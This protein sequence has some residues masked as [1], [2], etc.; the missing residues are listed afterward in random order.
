MRRASWKD[1]RHGTRPRADLSVWKREPP[2]VRVAVVSLLVLVLVCVA[3]RFVPAPRVITTP[4]GSVAGHLPLGVTPADLNL[5]V[6]TLDTTRADRIG[7]Y[8]WRDAGTPTLDRIAKDGVLFEQPIAPAPLTLPAHCSLFTGKNPPQHGVRDNG[9]FIL[10]ERETTLA[11]RLKAHG[12]KTAG[13]IGAWVLDRKWGIAQGFDTYFDDF[14]LSKYASPTLA[15][16]RRPGNEVADHALAWLQKVASSRF[17]AWVHFY[18]AHSPYAPPEPFRSRFAGH[19]Y[20]GELAF[21]DSQVARLVRFLEER[22]LLKKTIV[23]IVGDHGESLGEHGESTHGFFIYQSVLRVPLMIL[24]PFDVMH[25]RRVSDLVRSVDAMPT[26]LDLLGIRLSDKVDGR[27][28]VPLMTGAVH[29]LG[30]DAYSEAMYARYHYGWSDLRGLTSGRFKYIDAPR[31][32]LYDIEQDPG[33]TQNLYDERRALGDRMAR[34]LRANETQG[35]DEKPAVDVDPEA[36][37]RLAA[38]GYVGTFVAAPAKE[39]ATLADPKDKIELFNLIIEARELLQDKASA[40]AGL[41]ALRRVVAKDPNV[42]DAWLMIG[43]EFERRRQYSE[44]LDSYKQALALKPD[45]D[46]A[47][48]NVANVCREL[49]RNDDALIWYHRLTEMSPKNA[50]VRQEMAQVLIDEGKLAEAEREL[51]TALDLEPTM[52]TAQNSLGALRLKQG[53]AA[54]GEK[55]IRAALAQ[56]SDLPLAHFNLALIAEQRGDTAAAMAEYRKEIELHPNSY[57]AQFNLGKLYGQTGDRVAQL[58]AYRDAVA[59]NPS[60][61]EGH[62]FLAKLYLDI[63]QQLDEAVKLARRGVELAPHS[64]WA[65]LGHF[66]IADVYARQGRAVDAARE[67]AEGRLLQGARKR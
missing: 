27:S 3:S 60:F 30:L 56:K 67:A 15:D 4:S 22:D 53:D 45:Y 37:A 12:F 11:E 24:A 6:I 42:I 2:G 46:L 23:V 43:N 47:V 61:A 39:R 5:L 44:A 40:D 10:D 18:D 34:I 25:G 55:I 29:E 33:E 36:R 32:E 64:E 17:F 48:G 26:V 51:K 8:G 13:F 20:L 19:P 41:D 57:M 16:V 49:G 28:L 31:P 50:Q 7:A 14:D 35:T 52:A 65:P 38:L 9:G 21:V 63:G 66:V 1:R 59:S 62:L 58:K 54:T